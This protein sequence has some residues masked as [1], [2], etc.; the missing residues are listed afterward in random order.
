LRATLPGAGGKLLVLIHGSS[1]NDQQWHRLGHDHGAALARD[2]GYTAVY[3]RYNSGLH[4][5][6]NGR[7]CADLLERLVAEWPAPL[8]ELVIVGHSMGGLLARSA[9][10]AGERAGHAWR[11][12]LGTLICLGSPHHGAPLERGGNW[13]DLLLGS[14]PY[15]VPLGRLARI[16]SAGVTDLRFGNVRDEDWNGRDRFAF[17]GDT[18]TPLALPAGVQCYAIAGTK[19]PKAGGRL[20]GDGLVPVASALGRHDRPEL[21]LAFPEAHQFIGYGVGHIDL[22]HS[23]E[24]YE[25]LRSWLAPRR[26]ARIKDP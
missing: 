7:A 11:P 8:D 23:A 1:M 13:V 24:V 16:R 10:H 5:S 2:L 26:V 6:A 22:L 20:R 3:L 25:Q 15:T 21:T 19:T 12:K 18:R 9:C 4:I 14:S 17:G